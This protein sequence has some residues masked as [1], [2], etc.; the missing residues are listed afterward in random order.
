MKIASE[1]SGYTGSRG[2]LC[3]FDWNNIILY[4]KKCNNKQILGITFLVQNYTPKTY[5]I[6]YIEIQP[7][8]IS[9]ISFYL[10][11]NFLPI[12]YYNF[13]SVSRIVCH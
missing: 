1:T 2:K 11:Y 4:S 10:I 8:C 3:Y 5:D 13:F 9:L 12:L 6:P 7:F